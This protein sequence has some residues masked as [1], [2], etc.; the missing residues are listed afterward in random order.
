MELKKI[1]FQKVKRNRLE[2]VHLHK[3]IFVSFS[4]IVLLICAIIY[5]IINVN[6]EK[7]WA[8]PLFLI[9]SFTAFFYTFSVLFAKKRRG[10]IAASA[11]TTTLLIRI[12]GVNNVYF[13]LAVIIVAMI[14][15]VF[16]TLKNR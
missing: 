7:F 10:L 1:N 8:V 13:Y 16:L 2:N 9:L 14:V 15:E 3:N 4:I 12:V 6:P 11:L 5:L